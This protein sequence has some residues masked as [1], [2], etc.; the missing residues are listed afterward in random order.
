MK[1]VEEFLIHKKPEEQFD[2]LKLALT[3]RGEELYEYSNSN[4]KY[5]LQQPSWSRAEGSKYDGLCTP[6]FEC[7][8][9]RD[10]S[11][12]FGIGTTHD[13]YKFYLETLVL[14]KRANSNREF[15]GIIKAIDQELN[16]K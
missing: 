6:E 9:N 13:L 16:E 11:L 5:E 8:K 14:L 15:S 2:F 1:G 4:W 3:I 12:H 10:D 7:Y